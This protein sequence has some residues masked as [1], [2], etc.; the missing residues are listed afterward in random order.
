MPLDHTYPG[1]TYAVTVNVWADT[2][3]VFNAQRAVVQTSSTTPQYTIN[4]EELTTML[5]A[6][7][8]VALVVLVSVVSVLIYLIRSDRKKKSP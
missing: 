4:P 7:G 1:E 3:I 6:L 2:G 5:L 8:I